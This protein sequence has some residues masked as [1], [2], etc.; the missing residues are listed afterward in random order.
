MQKIYYVDKNYVLGVISSKQKTVSEFCKE[1]GCSRVNFYA[2]LNR[3]YRAPRSLFMSKVI[4]ELDLL[5]SLVWSE[6]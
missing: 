5:D 4:K 1:I 3:G 6:E 2:A